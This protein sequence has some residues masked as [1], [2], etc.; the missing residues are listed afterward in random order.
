MRRL[1][2]VR[3]R[4]RAP[5][6]YRNDLCEGEK[7]ILSKPYYGGRATGQKIQ[8]HNEAR[9]ESNLRRAVRDVELFDHL[10]AS[11]EEVNL[12]TQTIG[13]RHVRTW[14]M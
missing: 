4:K 13:S 6:V 3:T 5:L 10:N 1:G 2:G 14:F 11:A 9:V 8:A 12:L 7:R